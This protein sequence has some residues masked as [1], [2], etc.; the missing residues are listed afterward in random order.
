MGNISGYRTLP[1][2]RILHLTRQAQRDNVTNSIDQSSN[3]TNSNQG[4]LTWV[5]EI[6]HLPFSLSV[7]FS[8][9]FS[10][11]YPKQRQRETE[12]RVP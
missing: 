5:T 11:V 8:D 6:L 4:Q 12:R 3:V 7:S 9:G 1:R 2:Y 10:V